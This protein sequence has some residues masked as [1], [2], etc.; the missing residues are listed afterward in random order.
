VSFY[1]RYNGFGAAADDRMVAAIAALNVAD[2]AFAAANARVEAA[3]AAKAQ[4]ARMDSAW[5]K[6]VDSYFNSNGAYPGAPEVEL[7]QKYKMMFP[8]DWSLPMPSGGGPPFDF[9]KENPV[10]EEDKQKADDEVWAATN[11]V[12]AARSARTA[13]QTAQDLAKKEIDAVNVTAKNNSVAAA[14][15]AADAAAKAKQAVEMAADAKLKSIQKQM[16]KSTGPSPLIIAAVVVP[17]LGVV[18]W[19]LTRKKAAA[20]AGYRRRRSRR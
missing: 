12:P 11:A 2:A 5:F 8:I 19:A 9:D 3:K 20:V 10:L 15:A 14:K 13:A 7:Y 6:Q 1:G 17:V 4:L 18:I 16:A